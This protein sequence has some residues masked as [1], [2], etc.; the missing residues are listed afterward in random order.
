MNSFICWIGGKKLLRKE[1]VS[2]FP[3][4]IERYIEVFGGAGWV[5]FE[6]NQHS[7][8]EVYNDYNSNLVNLYKCIKYHPNELLKE[9]EYMINSRELFFDYISQMQSKGLT[10]I[11]RA[12]R[13]YMLIRCSYSSSLDS[14]GNKPRGL[15]KMKECFNEISKRLERVVIENK[16]FEDIIKL[17][18]KEGS[19]FYLDPPYYKTENYYQGF[20]K[21][22][23]E[24]LFN[25][26]KNCK[27]KWILSYNYDPYIEALYKDFIQINTKRNNNMTARYGV[28]RDYEE[29][30]IK[31]Y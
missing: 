26:L 19:L 16:D 24:R 18:D 1:I 25:A 30:I 20:S 27:S 7:K 17:Y 23:H 22:D 29:L 13:F 12:A 31:N 2:L 14:Y 9:L 8:F 15:S 21:E 11:Q 28:N 3:A 10:D 5:L 6:S 4:K